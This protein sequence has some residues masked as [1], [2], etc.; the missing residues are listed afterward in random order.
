MVDVGSLLAKRCSLIMMTSR[1]LTDDIEI[2]GE[3]GALRLGVDFAQIA[4]AVASMHSSERMTTRM[5]RVTIVDSPDVE[6]PIASLTFGRYLESCVG[7]ERL[8]AHSEQSIVGKS[9]PRDL[10]SS[11]SWARSFI[12]R[13][14][15][16]SLTRLGPP[17]C[18]P[19]R[20]ARDAD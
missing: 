7:G 3:Q 12:R 1:G 14:S 2:D 15:R 13:L 18:A 4:A 8:T 19:K 16:R 11:R 17:P 5:S 9:R 10:Q 6:D 20:R